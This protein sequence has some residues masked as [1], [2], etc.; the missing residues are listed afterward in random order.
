MI[1]TH[2]KAEDEV[3]SVPGN[4]AEWED[5]FVLIFGVAWRAFRDE[6]PNKE[7]WMRGIEDFVNKVCEKWDLP[8]LPVKTLNSLRSKTDQTRTAKVRK[9][10]LSLD[11]APRGH[12]AP[13]E[14]PFKVF[15]ARPHGC[16]VFI[17]DCKPLAEIICGKRALKT[18]RRVPNK[19]FALATA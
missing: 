19:P 2:W 7:A 13:E 6:F 1:S 10:A 17:V 8:L 11:L 14:L 16:I 12:E 9:T 15:W 3:H 4:V 5:L 18:K